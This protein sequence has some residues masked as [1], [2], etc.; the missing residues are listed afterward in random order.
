MRGVFLLICE[1]Y[2][3]PLLRLESAICLAIEAC[4]CGP[5][6]IQITHMF[7]DLFFCHGR[8]VV[9]FSL[10]ASFWY[11]YSKSVFNNHL[12]FVKLAEAMLTIK[13]CNSRLDSFIANPAS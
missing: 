9:L 12:F 2:L 3:S 10:K 6:V 8:I 11:M 13:L 4:L 7:G 5:P 1:A